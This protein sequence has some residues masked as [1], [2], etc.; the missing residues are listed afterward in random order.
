MIRPELPANE[1]ARLAALRQSQIL[2][3]SP[4]P[5]FDD[6][7]LLASVVCATRM[8]AVSLIDHDREW[9]KAAHGMQRRA[10]ARDL[11]F[12]AHAILDADRVLTVDDTWRDPR[13]HDHP[14]ATDATPV[15]FYAGAPLVTSQGLALG[16]LCVFDDR[17]AQ[18]SPTQRDALQALSRQ[19]AHLLELRRLGHALDRQLRERQWYEDRLMQYS[20][21]LEALNVELAQQT[22]TD[23]LTGLP[24]RRAFSEALAAL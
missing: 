7:A 22:R 5:A 18:L 2:D 11:S 20:T 19:A 16:T 21:Q 12:C 6:L 13:F 10:L 14:L 4:E 24:N 23:P 1:P 15:R 8:A 9:F 3:T 17:P